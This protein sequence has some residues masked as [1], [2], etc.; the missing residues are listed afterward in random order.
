MPPAATIAAR[1][2][3]WLMAR[4]HS[5]RA[6]SAA[7]SESG[8]TSPAR[9]ETQARPPLAWAALGR[10]RTGLTACCESIRPVSRPGHQGPGQ[11]LDQLLGPAGMPSSATSVG[12]APAAPMASWLATLLAA[13]LARQP[14]ASAACG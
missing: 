5:A 3:A 7:I 8:S 11:A 13:M 4:L 6:A 1:L 2:A 14:T 9:A 12:S 10:K